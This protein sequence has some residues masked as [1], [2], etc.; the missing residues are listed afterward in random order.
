MT[1]VYPR[2]VRAVRDVT[3][4]VAA[5]ECVAVVGPSGCG[6]TT[7]LRLV[8]GLEVPT[9]GEVRLGGRIVTSIR[10]QDR[11]IALMSQGHALYPQLTVRE[12]LAFGLRFRDVPRTEVEKRVG[13]MAEMLGLT[14]LLDRL[15]H[16]LSGGQQQR[17]ALGRCAARRPAVLLLDEPL[18]HLDAP[19]RAG[20]RAEIVRVRKQFGMTA[21]W[22]THD[23]D[24]ARAVGERV[25]EMKAN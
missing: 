20:V 1:K 5:G 22:V 16:Q 24:E 23:P 18:S 10:P 17:V 6:K 8:A 11:D 4:A 25:V 13:E 7:L 12:N 9:T 19:L 14:P 15:P 2:G 21:M 3:L